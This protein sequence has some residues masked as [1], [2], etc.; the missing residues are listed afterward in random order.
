MRGQLAALPEY[1]YYYAGLADK[2]QGDVIP[3]S[4]RGC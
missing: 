4:D 3:T 1:Y 2:I